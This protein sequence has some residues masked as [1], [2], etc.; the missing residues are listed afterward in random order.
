[1]PLE[2]WAEAV[3]KKLRILEVPVPLIYLDEARSFGGALDDMEQRLGVYREVLDRSI[4]QR[5]ARKAK[6]RQC[7]EIPAV[8]GSESAS[9]RPTESPCGEHM[10]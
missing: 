8:P 9:P 6:T 5:F 4:R 3:A 7:G 10:R 1:M 2:F